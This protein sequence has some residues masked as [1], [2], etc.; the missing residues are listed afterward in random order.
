MSKKFT[1]HFWANFG[2]RPGILPYWIP[3]RKNPGT[4]AKIRPKV[5]FRNFEKKIFND[6]DLHVSR[7]GFEYKIAPGLNISSPSRKVYE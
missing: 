6:L 5:A 1:R 3:I 4:F 7:G 2:D